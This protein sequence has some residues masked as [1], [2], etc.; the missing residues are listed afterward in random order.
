[1][2]IKLNLG[3]GDDIKPESEGW[4]NCDMFHS[5][6]RVKI[7][8]LN[9][10]PLPFEDNSV[11]YILLVQVLEHLT[12][13]PFEFVTDCYRILK[14]DGV[15]HIELPAFSYG[16]THNHG[17]YPFQ[18][19]NVLF[20]SGTINKDYHK[21]ADFEL[22]SFTKEKLGLKDIIWRIYYIFKS[23]SYG[24]LEWKLKKP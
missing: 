9:K 11:D 18:Y 17:F 3:C 23:L 22:I 12:I 16:L 2:V 1:M 5:D 13:H 24:N 6:P 21:R 7:V 4:I 19:M 20:T 10:L 8:D 15:L 14:K